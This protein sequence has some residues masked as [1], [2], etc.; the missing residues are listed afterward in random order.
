V[1]SG[2]KGRKVVG[3]EQRTTAE[4]PEKNRGDKVKS[5]EQSTPTFLLTRNDQDKGT[6]RVLVKKAKTAS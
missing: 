6:H 3:C 4:E 5:T 1:E 2:K